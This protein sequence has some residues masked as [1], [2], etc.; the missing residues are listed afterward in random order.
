MILILAGIGAAVAFGVGGD[1]GQSSCPFAPGEASPG[2]GSGCGRQD[3]PGSGAGCDSRSC[4]LADPSGEGNGT[5]CCDPGCLNYDNCT[6]RG[7]CILGQNASCNLT[8]GTASECLSICAESGI[9]SQDRLKEGSGC[10]GRGPAAAG[11]CLLDGGE[12]AGQETGYRCPAAGA[13]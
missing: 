13:C 12:G 7:C 11:R 2:A 1:A 10:Q 3:C 8:N 6:A 5:E 4:C 9:K